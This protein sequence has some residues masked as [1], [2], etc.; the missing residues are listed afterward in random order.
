L[1]GFESDWRDAY[2]GVNAV[3]LMELRNPPDERQKELLPIV[4]YAVKRKMASGKS[5][6]WDYAT[7]LE[8]A[9]LARDEEKAFDALGA[10]VTH[11]REKWEPES[12]LKNIT[13]IATARQSRGEVI[14]AWL[15]TVLNELQKAAA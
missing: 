10:A 5:D 8:L 9:V 6:Y 7:L 3:T 15:N 4:T 11:I 12:T 1:K 13:M 14:P 2:P